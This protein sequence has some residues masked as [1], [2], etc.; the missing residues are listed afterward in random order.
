ML[1]EQTEALFDAEA[2]P[3]GVG[4]HAIAARAGV[5]IG[6]LYPYFPN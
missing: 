2:Q 5:G 3:L 4:T 6:S 1:F